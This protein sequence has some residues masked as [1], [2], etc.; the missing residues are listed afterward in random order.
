M[1]SQLFLFS[2]TI[3]SYFSPHTQTSTLSAAVLPLCHYISLPLCFACRHTNI[4]LP[5]CFLPLCFVPLLPFPSFGP[6]PVCLVLGNATPLHPQSPTNPHTLQ[7]HIAG[8]RET[9]SPPVCLCVGGYMIGFKYV[10]DIY[11][12]V[13]VPV[14]TCGCAC[15]SRADAIRPD[16]CGVI[17]S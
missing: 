17:G 8:E 10:C 1:P 13:C 5:T 2:Y 9:H 12:C 14:S 4:I 11:R 15:V 16:M 7:K 3:F 6:W